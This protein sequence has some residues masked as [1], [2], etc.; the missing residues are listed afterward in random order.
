MCIWE[1]PV[2]T[3]KPSTHSLHRPPLAVNASKKYLRL[4][5]PALARARNPRVPSV[6]LQLPEFPGM[7][8]VGICNPFSLAWFVIQRQLV[9]SYSPK[10]PCWDHVSVRHQQP[11]KFPSLCRPDG[12]PSYIFNQNL[13]VLDGIT[14][15]VSDQSLYSNVHLLQVFQETA[16]V[17]H[18]FTG[19]LLRRREFAAAQLQRHLETVREHVVEVLHASVELVPVGSIGDP[20][21]KRIIAAVALSHSRVVLRVDGGQAFENGVVRCHTL[22]TAL[23]LI[24]ADKDPRGLFNNNR[25]NLKLKQRGC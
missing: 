25:A 4:Y 5:Q 16:L 6:R 17:L 12:L 21:L 22:F 7:E 18:P 13:C 10:C 14:I 8:P 2:S 15:D 20:A 1:A 24:S 11:P 3:L 19:Q 23:V 9:Y